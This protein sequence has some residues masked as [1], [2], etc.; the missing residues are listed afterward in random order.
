MCRFDY[1]EFIQDTPFKGDAFF[2]NGSLVKAH[3]PAPGEILSPQ[4]CEDNLAAGA[5]SASC[6]QTLNPKPSDLLMSLIS[7]KSP[8]LEQSGA[9]TQLTPCTDQLL[10]YTT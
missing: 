5:F 1:S 2:G 9:D 3:M 8:D 7:S 10:L 4:Q 6:R